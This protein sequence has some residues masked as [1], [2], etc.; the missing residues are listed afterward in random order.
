MPNFE[1]LP[2]I[3]QN[4]VGIAIYRYLAFITRGN[5]PQF[6]PYLLDKAEFWKRKNELK[7]QVNAVIDAIIAEGNEPQTIEIS[8][9]LGNRGL[10]TI[11][12]VLR[13]RGFNAD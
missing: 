5:N 9:R 7:T 10:A 1:N 3:G 2:W 8:K 11:R 13:Q 6:N 12:E 4:V